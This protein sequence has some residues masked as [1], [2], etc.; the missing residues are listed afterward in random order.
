[1][2]DSLVIFKGR[3][4]PETLMEVESF[5]LDVWK[6]ILDYEVASTRFGLDEFFELA[7]ELKAETIIPVN[8]FDAYLKRKSLEDAV[9]HAVVPSPARPGRWRHRSPREEIS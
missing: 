1:M 5:R 6:E 2:T 7:H 8:F 4:D 3:D 9:D